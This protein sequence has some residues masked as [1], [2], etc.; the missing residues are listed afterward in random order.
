MSGKDELVG[1]EAGQDDGSR[2]FLVS[3]HEPPFPPVPL[4]L[5]A[6]HREPS[7]VELFDHETGDD[8]PRRRPKPSPVQ[9]GAHRVHSPAARASPPF[10]PQC[11]PFIEDAFDVSVSPDLLATFQAT[12]GAWP[13]VILSELDEEGENDQ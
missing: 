5:S 2:I 1:L 12:A 13:G 10:D 6:D 4:S 8:Q 11:S 9:Q 7:A 3:V